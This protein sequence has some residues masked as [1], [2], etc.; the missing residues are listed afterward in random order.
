MEM[1]ISFIIPAHNEEHYLGRTLERLIASAEAVGEPFEVIVVADGCTDE[2]SAVA[3]T[4]GSRLIE[5][6]LRHI[7]AVRNTGAKVA[8]GELFVFVDAD[9]LVPEETLRATVRV[10]RKGATGGGAR[11]VIDTPFPWPARAFLRVLACVFFRSF[12]FTLGGY[13]FATRHAFEAVGGFDE[14]YFAAEDA[15]MCRA[16]RKHGRFVVLRE[17]MIT[18]GRKIN[19]VTTWEATMIVARLLLRG[20]KAFRQ[21]QGLEIWYDQRRGN[22]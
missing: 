5:V 19:E 2:T 15:V 21:R 22:Q 3:R 20:R 18:S 9:T 16:L 12:T 7:A 14:R 13:V 8:V 10:V 11:A 4:Y 1:L 6:D 17:P